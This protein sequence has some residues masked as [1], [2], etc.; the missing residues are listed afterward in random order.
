MTYLP[1]ETRPALEGVKFP[2]TR[3]ALRDRAAET[4]RVL[5]EA[6]IR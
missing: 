5:K 3:K 1:D 6:G 2:P 4:D